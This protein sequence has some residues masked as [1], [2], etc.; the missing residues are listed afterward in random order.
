MIDLE[1][2]RSLKLGAVILAVITLLVLAVS[3]YNLISFLG[4]VMSG[5]SLGLDLEKNESTGEWVMLFEASPRNDGIL[6][7]SFYLE[8]TLF[9]L[10][11]NKI[12]T[13]SS[14]VTIGAGNTQSFSFSLVIPPDFVQ[15]DDLQGD[16]GYMQMTMS[17]MTLGDLV[18]LTQ[19]MKVG[20][21]GES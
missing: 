6:P 20:G 2:K 8:I 12:A 18:G 11:D 4:T 5:D 17:I 3:M 19:I 13:N 21:A 1:K 14:L 10:S 15:G 16:E 9:D 7:V